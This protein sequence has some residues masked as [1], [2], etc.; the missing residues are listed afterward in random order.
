MAAGRA[1]A[2]TPR[3]HRRAERRQLARPLP[4]RC[5]VAHRR[6]ERRSRERDQLGVERGEPVESAPPRLAAQAA[7]PLPRAASSSRRDAI[8]QRIGGLAE[9]DR[10][11]AGCSAAPA[12]RS[13]CSGKR[14][15]ATAGSKAGSPVADDR[16]SE[17]PTLMPGGAAPLVEHIEHVRFAEVDLHR[18][19]PRPLAVVA[20]EVA[21]DAAQAPPSAARRCAAQRDTMLERR[22]DDPD[23]MSVVLAAQVG[24]D[25]AAVLGHVIH[26]TICDC[27]SH[28]SS[29]SAGSVPRRSSGPAASA[30]RRRGRM[31]VVSGAITT[32]RPPVATHTALPPSSSP[33]RRTSPSTIPT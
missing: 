30:R 29:G 12:T 15:P 22:T 3:R 23:Q 16:R 9:R 28:V 18:P 27:T 33:I 7:A 14:R 32:A 5:G 19:P 8:D 24:F 2:R 31:S 1:R 25:L 17:R 26:C 13:R 10:S 11:R 21:I 6:V 4:R 20:L